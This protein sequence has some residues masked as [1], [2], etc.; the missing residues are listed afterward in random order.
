MI[1]LDPWWNAATEQQAFGR[2][3]RM[4]QDKQ[5]YF[6]RILVNNTIDVR[7]SELQREKLAMV[8]KTIKEHDPSKVTLSAEEIASLLG[9]VVRD[10]SG[11]IIAI[12]ADYDDESDEATDDE[13]AGSNAGS[14]GGAMSVDE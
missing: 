13:E 5:T 10:E 14:S 2:V 6:L 9:R 7:M 12:R 3:Y 11:N 1:I 8:N 4:G